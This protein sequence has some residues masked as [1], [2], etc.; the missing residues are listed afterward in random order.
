MDRAHRTLEFQVGDQVWFSMQNINLIGSRKLKPK[1]IGPF[2]VVE[3]IGHVAYH[4]K[5]PPSMDRIHPTFHVGLLKRCILGGDGQVRNTTP[6]IEAEDNQEYVVEKIIK[7]RVTGHHKKYFIRWLGYD[8][9][10]DSWL[11]R[12]ELQNAPQVLKSWT[13][14]Q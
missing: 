10:Y 3:R 1:F 14:H 4:L 8:I 9:T 2:L 7:E 12:E 6:A 13:T 11:T 5:L